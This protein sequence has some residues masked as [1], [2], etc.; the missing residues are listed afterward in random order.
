MTGRVEAPSSRDV[1]D[2]LLD[3]RRTNA[4]TRL[5]DKIRESGGRI[6]RSSFWRSSIAI[7]NRRFSPTMPTSLRSLRSGITFQNSL[8]STS[9]ES[10]PVHVVSDARPGWSVPR[11]RSSIL[12]RRGCVPRIVPNAGVRLSRLW[13]ASV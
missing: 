2:S 8:S 7:G 9:A 5:L 10:V 3:E 13:R 4:H 1:A 12:P 6:S 11:W